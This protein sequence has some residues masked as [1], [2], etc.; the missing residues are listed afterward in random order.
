MR[1]PSFVSGGV[2]NHSFDDSP[3]DRIT[4]I[5]SSRGLMHGKVVIHTEGPPSRRALVVW[6]LESVVGSC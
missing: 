4:S 3:Y 6:R 2:I 1:R 5:T